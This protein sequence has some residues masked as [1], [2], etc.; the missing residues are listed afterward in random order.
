MTIVQN[1]LKIAKENKINNQK[2]CEILNSNPNK[3][4]DWKVGKSKP[5]TD[6]LCI[7]ADYFNVSADYLLGRTNEQ[8]NNCYSNNISDNSFNNFMQG[9]I[10]KEDTSIS[11]PASTNKSTQLSKEETEILDIYR[12]LDIRNKS[13]FLNMIFDIEKENANWKENLFWNL[14]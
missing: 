7:L 14:L 13:K 2:L 3:I 4:Y 11:V 12:S 8:T 1:I 10:I 9:N 6:E 5:S